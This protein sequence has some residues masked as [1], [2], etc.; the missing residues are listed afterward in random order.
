MNPVGHAVEIWNGRYRLE[1][2]EKTLLSEVNF[3]KNKS[4]IEIKPY[5]P[6]LWIKRIEIQLNVSARTLKRIA[7]WSWK[8][9]EYVKRA[10]NIWKYTFINDEN[11]K[12]NKKIKHNIFFFIFNKWH[13]FYYNQNKFLFQWTL[14]IM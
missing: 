10:L 13:V 2:S 8:T 4:A 5:M 3:F 14:I 7:S 1:R 11:Y 6:G 12:K 9:L